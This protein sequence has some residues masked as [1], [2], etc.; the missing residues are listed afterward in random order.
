MAK[1]T[2]KDLEF[3]VTDAGGQQKTF[4]HVKDAI[5]LAANVSMMTERPCHVDVLTWSRGAARHWA[6]D[7][8]AESYDDDP[9]ASVF[10]R[11]EIQFKS[12]GKVP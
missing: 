5:L 7:E 4:K 3:A 11:L 6:G 12:L 10:E 2:H 8:G 1:T 9:D